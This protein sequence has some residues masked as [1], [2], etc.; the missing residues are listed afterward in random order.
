MNWIEQQMAPSAMDA[1]LDA[2]LKKI[3]ALKGWIAIETAPKDKIIFLATPRKY[4]FYCR[5]Y[6]DKWC[7]WGLDDFD[8]MGW[9][10]LDFTPS[11]WMPLPPFPES[12][13]EGK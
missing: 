2:D 11:H 7:F 3:N 6:R 4:E 5:W 10:T 12:R 13:E 1:A 9:V 8:G